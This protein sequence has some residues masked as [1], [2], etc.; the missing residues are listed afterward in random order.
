V[1]ALARKI[2]TVSKQAAQKFHG[3]RFNLR[4]LNE[5]KFR[6]QYEIDITNRS[7][8]LENLSDDEDINMAWENVKENIKTSAGDSPGLYELKQHKSCFDE[9]CLGSFDQR[10]QA[11]FQWIQH[12]SQ[13]NVANLNNVRHDASTHFRNK[14]KE[15]LKAKIEELETNYN[16]NIRHMYRDII[17]F[18]NG[19]QP[20]NVMLCRHCFSLLLNFVL[21]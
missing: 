16:K 2:L 21:E 17:D 1:V 20:I 7:A 3:E 19:Y 8:A 6:K 18:K 14:K 9:E 15:Y 10:E 4:K 11:K 13:S 5:V 12:P